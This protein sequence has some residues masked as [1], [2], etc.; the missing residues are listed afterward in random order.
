[1]GVMIS[2]ETEKTEKKTVVL[3]GASNKTDR[4][5]YK[6]L[7]ML[8]DY[9]YNVIPI[10]PVLDNIESVPVKHSI[11]EILQPVHTVTLYLNSSRLEPIIDEIISLKP[12]RVI[13]NPG[14]ESPEAQKRMTA[15]GI[16]TIEACTL[17]LLRTGR[18]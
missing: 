4:Y 2:S 16:E 8:L 1:M 9:G 18:F 6:A 14:T 3:L 7:R 11:S 12:R 10:N 5:S 15:N 13:F 17:V